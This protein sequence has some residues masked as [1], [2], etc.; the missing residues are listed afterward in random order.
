MSTFFQDLRYAVRTLRHDPAFAVVAIVVLAL[1]IGANSAVFS[2]V[3]AMLVRPLPGQVESAVVGI[4]SRDTVEPDAYRAFSWPEF[5]DVRQGVPGLSHVTAHTISMV[6]LADGDTTRRVMAAIVAANYFETLGVPVAK[7]R[8]FTS[9]EE[10]PGAGEQVVVI[11]DPLARRLGGEALGTVIR[12]NGDLFTVV[13]V[14]AP[15]FTGTTALISPEVWVPIGA[16]HLVATD[17]V[18]DRRQ[19]LTARATRPFMLM[20]RLAAGASVGSVDAALAQVSERLEAAHPAESRNQRLVARPMSRVG[21]STSPSDDSQVVRLSLLLM[22]MAG[23]V[24]LIASLNLANMLLARHAARRKEMAIRLALGGGRARIVRQLLTEGLVLALAGGA[25]G[26]LLAWWAMAAIVSSLAAILPLTFAL[27]SMPDVR[28]LGAT[29]GFSVLATLAFALLP[30]VKLARP[31]VVDDLKDHA[32]ELGGRVG[33]RGL[34]ALRNLLVVSQ[35]ALSLALLTAGGLFVRGAIKAAEADPGFPMTGGLVA[36]LDP[37]LGGYDEVRSRTVYARLLERVRAMPGVDH[38]SLASIVP[39]GAFT[40]SRQV[41]RA[42]EPTDGAENRA[43]GVRSIQTIVS[44]DYFRSLGLP[45]LRGRDFTPGEETSSD[46]SRSVVINEPL[47]RRLWPDDDPIGQR[48]QIP[49]G[50]DDRSPAV[51]EVVGV[52]AGVRHSLFDREP[53]AH[54]YLPF[55]QHYQPAMTL[56]V[57]VSGGSDR[58]RL[59]ALRDE[60]RGLDEGLPVLSLQ[61]LGEFRDQNVMLWAVKTGARLFTSF[62]LVALLLAG[63]GLYGVKAYVVSR[64][65]REIG[66]RMALGATERDVLWMVWREGFAVAGVGVGVGVVLAVLAGQAI[67][68]LLYEVSAL[69]PM[70]F[71]VAPVVLLVAASLACYLPARRATRVAP[72]T[73]LRC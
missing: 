70:V 23:I 45:V 60:L 2:L 25:A 16:H 7:G 1:G 48:V 34:F 63:V 56:H 59:P 57:R 21:I 15:G 10:R 50:R 39:F 52:V 11:G 71:I 29:L 14:A 3:N 66:I 37:S 40:I 55:G 51:F 72:L 47:A 49:S 27:D 61:T 41:F 20:G 18:S 5:D 43:R 53:V 58:A 9:S 35:V 6:G 33:G 31:G 69:D 24:L 36:A 68:R 32:G 4:Y 65:T 12:I 19:D 28:V 64:R 38:A 67:G 22:S 73:A 26:L 62:G 8:A 44:A 46:G 17:L 13:G 54:V 42:G 30:A